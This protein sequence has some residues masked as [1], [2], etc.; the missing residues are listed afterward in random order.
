MRNDGH[1]LGAS[2]EIETTRVYIR[3]G[4]HIIGASDEIEMIRVYGI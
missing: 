4:G 1:I 3:N 2:D